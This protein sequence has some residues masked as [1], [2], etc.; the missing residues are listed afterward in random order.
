MA[1]IY[2]IDMA[3]SSHKGIHLSIPEQI[4]VPQHSTVQWTISRLELFP[5]N[6]AFF[7]FEVQVTIIFADASPFRW[8]KRS[9]RIHKNNLRQFANG[10]ATVASDEAEEKGDFK[11]CVR[12]EETQSKNTLFEEDPYLIVY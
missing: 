8:R 7:A 4:R 9:L 5:F 2:H 12:V 10:V 6:Q 3:L 1:S 11:Y